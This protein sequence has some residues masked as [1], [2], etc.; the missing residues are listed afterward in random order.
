M[1]LAINIFAMPN[2]QNQHGYEFV[3]NVTDQAVIAHAIAPKTALL[4]QQWLAPLPRILRNH[5][6]LTQK[7]SDGLLRDPP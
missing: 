5:K 1:A 6:P 4:T 7:L 2:F 3:L